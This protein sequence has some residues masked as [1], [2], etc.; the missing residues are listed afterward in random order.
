[1]NSDSE[2]IP[3]CNNQT[4]GFLRPEVQMP[5]PGYERELDE[6]VTRCQLAQ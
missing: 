5:L 2:I 6:Y 4:Y 3:R 1:M